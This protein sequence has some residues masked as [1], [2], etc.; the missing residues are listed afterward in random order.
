MIVYGKIVEG[1]LRITGRR[2]AEGDKLVQNITR[3]PS[4]DPGAGKHWERTEGFEETETTIRGKWVAVDDV[5]R[6]SKKRLFL[7]LAR[8]GKYRDFEEW[9]QQAEVIAGSGLTVATLLTQSSYMASDDEDFK[10]ILAVAVQRYG[11]AMVDELLAES[12]DVET[13]AGVEE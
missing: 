7:A 2:P 4:G 13:A 9:T 10:T 1:R 12:V 5:V 11:Q 3:P 6:Y 8:R